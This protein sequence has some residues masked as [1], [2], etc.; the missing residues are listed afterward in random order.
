[1][2]H[3]LPRGWV[4]RCP[5]CHGTGLKEQPDGERR[6]CPTCQGEAIHLAPPQYLDPWELDAKPRA[7]VPPPSE[8]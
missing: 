6:L 8:A 7:A 3:D 2:I 1:V 5:T 4:V